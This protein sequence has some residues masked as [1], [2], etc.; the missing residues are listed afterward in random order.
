MELWKSQRQNN[1]FPYD[2]RG[3]KF[4]CKMVNGDPVIMKYLYSS[5]AVSS[6]VANA[7]GQCFLYRA[8]KLHL[9]YAEAANRDNQQK[10]A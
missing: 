4:T 8:A 5:E 3:S 1:G 2:A 7:K 10:V 6:A 9:R